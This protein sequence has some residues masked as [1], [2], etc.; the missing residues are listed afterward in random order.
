MPKVEFQKLWDSHPYPDA[1]CD[2]DRFT[3]Q[4]AIRMTVALEKA[5]VDTR[6]FDRMYPKGRC[7]TAYLAYKHHKPGHILR[8]QQLA[9]W[10]KTQ[11]DRV[12]KVKVYKMQPVARSEE[13]RIVFI[14]NGWGPTDHID[15]WKASI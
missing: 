14:K 2:T 3:N 15:V 7:T 1:P 8:A 5:G 13:K 4:C 10:L 12:G 9:D 6:S 11:E